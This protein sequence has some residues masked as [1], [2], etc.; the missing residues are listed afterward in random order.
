MSQINISVIWLNY[1]SMKYLNVA[2]ESLKS[3]YISAIPLE[4]VIVD[5]NSTDRSFDEIVFYA[6]RLREKDF[7]VKVIRLNKNIGY[8]G[9]NN[10]GYLNS[11]PKAKY[12]AFVNNDLILYEDSLE[13]IIR[14]LDK[15]KDIGIA[16]GIIYNIDGKRIDN[17]G[18]MCTETLLG[19]PIKDLPREPFHVTYASGAYMVVKKEL[20]L[21]LGVPFDWDG[22]MYFDDMP[23]GFK[24]WHAGFKVTSLPISAGRHL[25]GASGGLVSEK[26]I[27]Y[28]YRGWGIMIEVSN[29]RFNKQLKSLFI[30][31]LP[32]VHG[33]GN[34]RLI[35]AA[36][37]GF[38]DGLRLGNEKRKQGYSLNIYSAPLITRYNLL[39]LLL[40]NRLIS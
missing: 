18:F 35:E 34:P 19:I 38:I 8:T 26:T 31:N 10:I 6:N 24:A 39:S 29:T 2:K 30:K 40:P 4:L 32:I 37:K 15:H 23:L 3:I 20:L 9:G 14:Y 13:R 12:V 5:N 11:D 7:R 25:S 21:R 33:V 36:L 28:M 16:Q 27:Y 1:N 17:V 22:F